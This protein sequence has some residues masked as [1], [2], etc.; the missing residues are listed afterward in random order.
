L[1]KKRDQ[2]A[3]VVAYH[4][5]KLTRARLD[6]AHVEGAL[7]LFT[8]EGQRARDA[9]YLDADWLCPQRELV[10]LC[11]AALAEQGPLTSKLLAQHVM[12]AKGMDEADA[13]L[14][15]ALSFRIAQALMQRVRRRQMERGPKRKGARVWAIKRERESLKGGQPSRESVVESEHKY[16]HAISLFDEI[17]MSLKQPERDPVSWNLSIGLSQLAEAIQQDLSYLDQR[18]NE[19]DNNIKNIQRR[20]SEPH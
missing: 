12:R 4:E 2:V 16:A 8:P 11:E 18:L 10:A 13:P 5:A 20:L 6:L 1:R 7:A 15:N 14:R 19:I 3:A 17:R 9:A